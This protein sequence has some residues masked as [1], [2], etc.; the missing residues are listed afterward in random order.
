M[1]IAPYLIGSGLAIVGSGLACSS[2]PTT[3]TGVVRPQLVAVDPDDFMGDVH[4]EPP[5]ADSAPRDPAAVHS[6]VATLFDVTPDVDGGV[7]NPGTPLPSSLPTTCAQPVTFAYVV[8]GHRYLAEID[9]Y[10]E[11]PDQLFPIS[12]GSR[13]VTDANSTRVVPG[14]PV[15]TCGGYAPSPAIGA[16][17]GGGAGGS[18]AVTGGSGGT[19]GV[20]RPPGVISYPAIT[21]TPHDCVG[22][23]LP[24]DN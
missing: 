12:P 6:Y 24:D 18:A 20:E 10:H 22:L 11:E 9:A 1:R 19:A 21:Q 3:S 2:T 8:E 5:P 16:G 4:C 7:P 14:W 15:A 23:R 17:G 13:L